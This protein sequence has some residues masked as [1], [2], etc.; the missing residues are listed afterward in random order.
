MTRSVAAPSPRE[1]AAR[2]RSRRASAAA[3]SA[4]SQSSRC[5]SGGRGAGAGSPSGPARSRAAGRRGRGCP[6]TST[7]SRRR[8]RPSR[9]ARR[10]WAN[11]CVRVDDL[12]LRGAHLVVREDQ[13]A[14]AALHVDRRAPPRW[15]T[16]DRRAL[17]VP[18]GAAR[19]RRASPR[20]ARPAARDARAGSP[21]GPSCRAG[22]GLPRAR[23]RPPASAR[24][25]SRDTSPKAGSRGHREVEVASSV[26]SDRPAAGVLELLDHRHDQRDRLDGA[27]VGVRRRA[28]AA[29]PCRCGRAGSR[30]RRAPASPRRSPARSSSGSSTSVTFCT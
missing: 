3:T 9:R 19:V 10:R 15:C 13:V 25:S 29:P 21:A 24:G 11:G 14:A 5:G 12:R 16:R 20:P 1:T 18:A 4:S 6:W 8:G 26:P 23:R 30:A 27:D 2:Q 22:R 7:S 28:P 17:D